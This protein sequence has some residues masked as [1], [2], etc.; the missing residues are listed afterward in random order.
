MSPPPPPP[1]WRQ[2]SFSLLLGSFCIALES[3]AQGNSATGANSLLPALFNLVSVPANVYSSTHPIFVFHSSFIIFT[4]ISPL[5]T[6]YPSLLP[7][8]DSARIHLSF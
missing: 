4:H 8:V 5:P 1:I 7:F 3:A 6:Q 2:L